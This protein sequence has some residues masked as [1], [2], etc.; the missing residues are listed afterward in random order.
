MKW[1][2]IKAIIGIAGLMLLCGC[3]NRY[4]APLIWQSLP[5]PYVPSSFSERPCEINGNVLVKV[6]DKR[7][8]HVGSTLPGTSYQSQLINDNELINV[9]TFIKDRFDKYLQ[10]IGVLTLPNSVNTKP[11]YPIELDV[12]TVTP[13]VRGLLW[14]RAYGMVELY[15]KVYKGDTLLFDKLYQAV[16]KSGDDDVPPPEYAELTIEFAGKL[17]TATS[18]KRIADELIG[19]ICKK[20]KSKLSK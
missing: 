7:K 10:N 13:Q 19:D 15:A 5:Y 12:N 9:N 14:I 18:I 6:N 2:N 4:Q 20:T 11:D 8:E 1:N 3:Y 16:A 17:V